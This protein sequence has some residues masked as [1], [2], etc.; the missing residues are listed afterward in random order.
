MVSAEMWDAAQEALRRNRTVGPASGRVY[1]L[2]SVMKCG[3]CGLTYVGSWNRNSV[4]YRCGGHL[5]GRGPTEGKCN[6]KDIKGDNIEPIIKADIEAFLRNPG[7]IIKELS[8]ERE[9]DSA[10]AIREAEKITLEGALA[11]LAIRRKNAIDLRMRGRITDAEIDEALAQVDKEKAQVEERLKALTPVA[12]EEEQEPLT[13]DILA[14]LRKRLDAELTPLQWQEIVRLLVKRITIY[15]EGEGLTRKARA[16]IE[17]RFTPP[18]PSE[19]LVA[20]PTCTGTGSSRRQEQFGGNPR[21]CD[22]SS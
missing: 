2:K 13:E 4:Y 12:V 17:Y 1:I 21:L 10:A 6:A 9:T 18:S 14:E 19:A 3:I 20:V 22:V 11:N 5:T 15:T 7:D 8:Q 16:V